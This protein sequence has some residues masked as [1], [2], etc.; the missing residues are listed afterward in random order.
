MQQLKAG[1]EAAVEFSSNE[2]NHGILFLILKLL[3][4][5]FAELINHV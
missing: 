4:E 1:N 3:K 5:S 2:G